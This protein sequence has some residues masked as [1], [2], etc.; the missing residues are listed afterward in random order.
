M[1]IAERYA[2]QVLIDGWGADGQERLARSSVAVVGLGGLGSPAS[3][4]LAAA[5]VGRLRL[6]DD[7]DVEESNLNRQVLYAAA[8][9]GT[10]KA[11]AAARRL[12]A[13]NPDIVVEAAA[14]R[15][16]PE[17]AEELLGDVDLI[18]DGL[19]NPEARHII[20]RFCVARRSPFVHAGVRDF[21]GQLMLIHPPRT[22]C[23]A[24]FFPDHLPDEGPLPIVGSSAG[25]L[26]SLEANLAIRCLVGLEGDAEGV[27]TYVDL[28]S[29]ETTRIAMPANPDCP[30]CG[31]STV[32]LS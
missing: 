8:E 21:F 28:A 20:N 26:G 9:I 29:L 18:V 27:L 6:I 12:T 30:V 5:G 22:A 17:N 7:Q 14:E 25:V 19:D 16:A 23:L 11:A 4:Y 1:D 2:R 32:P 13:L 15:L 24:C 31:T 3:L 10:P